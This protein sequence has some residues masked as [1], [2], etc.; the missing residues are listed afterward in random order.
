MWVD[1]CLYLF[2]DEF[3]VIS[4]HYYQV[5]SISFIEILLCMEEEIGLTY[6]IST[7]TLLFLDFKQR[8]IYLWTSILRSLFPSGILVLLKNYFVKSWG[9]K[10]DNTFFKSH[11]FYSILCWIR[12]E[13]KYCTKCGARPEWRKFSCPSIRKASTLRVISHVKY[14]NSKV[15]K[16]LKFDI[17]SRFY[18]KYEVWIFTTGQ[19]LYMIN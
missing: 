11:G 18:T 5:F 17:Y 4:W 6:I 15:N 12:Q 8:C 16:Y 10:S 1:T 13:L 3:H 19:Y 2:S 7:I 14:L 9:I